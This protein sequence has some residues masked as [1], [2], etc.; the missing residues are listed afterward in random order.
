MIKHCE[1]PPDVRVRSAVRLHVDL[2][3]GSGYLSAQ[4]NTILICVSAHQDPMCSTRSSD[5]L[6][7][8]LLF[9]HRAHRQ[10]M[11][12]CVIPHRLRSRR[13]TPRAIAAVEIAV[14]IFNAAVYNI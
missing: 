4:R 12:I 3:G 9:A 10:R 7:V 14:P 1:L 13:A 2:A 5:A 11:D 8:L 6:W